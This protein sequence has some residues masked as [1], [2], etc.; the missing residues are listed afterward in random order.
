MRKLTRDGSAIILNDLCATGPAF[1]KANGALTE[2]FLEQNDI[3]DQGAMALAD[4]L[5]ATFAIFF[6]LR[7]WKHVLLAIYDAVSRRQPS[8][9]FDTNEFNFDVRVLDVLLCGSRSVQREVRL[10]LTSSRFRKHAHP[11]VLHG[12]SP[13]YSC[14]C[15]QDPETRCVLSA[16]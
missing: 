11:R 4:A 10:F 9:I 7:C 1:H 3:G 12:R 15:G 6:F 13:R 8:L 2:L 5:K 16:C 14:L